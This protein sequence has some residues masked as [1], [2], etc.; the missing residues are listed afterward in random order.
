MNEESLR[1]LTTAALANAKALLQ[2]A[3]LLAHNRHYPRAYFLAVAS[4]EEAGKAA[5][6]HDAP[7]RNLADQAVRSKTERMLTD[8]ASK[9][10][11][12][13]TGFIVADPRKNVERAVELIVQLQR[14]REPSMYTEIRQ[15]NSVYRPNDSVSETNAT[16]CIRLADRCLRSI[17]NHIQS[18]PTRTT[19]NVEDRLFS[20]RSGEMSKIMNRSDFW[21]YYIA[22][23]E[24][25]QK[26]LASA[27]ISYRHDYL[28][29]GREFERDD[30]GSAA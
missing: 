7:G 19:T 25:G 2:E 17:E 8:H 26:D 13:F 1:N 18:V 21:W 14:G 11:A 28:L 3:S 12:A 6:A 16:D 30:S 29:A 5:I 10:R 15:D 22:R 20:L 27:V 24:T 23:M 9:I 4:I